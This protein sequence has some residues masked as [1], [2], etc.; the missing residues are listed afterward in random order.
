KKA[1]SVQLIDTIG[2]TTNLLRTKQTG[3]CLMR[4]S[5]PEQLRF[6]AIEGLTV[7]GDFEGG[8]LSSDFGTILL[9]ETESQIGLIDRLTNAIKDRRHPSYIEHSMQALLTQRIFQI[10]CGYEDGNDSNTLRQDP[11]FKLGAGRRLLDAG[12][13][14]AHASTF[15]RLSQSLSRSDIH[16][17]AQ[18]F[19]EH[20][21]ASYAA[22]PEVIVLDLDY[23]DHLVYGQ[24]EFA[25]FNAHYGDDCYLPLLIFEG[26]SGRLISVILRPGKRP[27]GRENAAIL[28]RVFTG[29]RQ[30]WPDT[31]IVVRGDMG[32]AQ[33]ELMRV[34]QADTC[35]DFVF[36]LGAGHPTALRPQAQS[37]LDEARQAL[38]EGQALASANSQP[39]PER[40]R[41]YGEADYRAHSWTGIDWSR[42]LQSRSHAVG[43]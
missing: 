40:V 10:A 34:V 3:I 31:H 14:L 37:L 26:L 19:L 38:V 33:P 22:P 1:G 17:M 32:F 20:F 36:G 21:V 28:K 24:Q 30:H 5:K 9:R 8:A 18:A 11:M 12:Q 25:L 13:D 27:T 23:T 29:L 16:R 15:T 35:A 39:E 43:R 42:V 2:F 7:R 4:H 6:H 41:L